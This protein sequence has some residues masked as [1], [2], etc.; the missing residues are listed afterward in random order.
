MDAFFASIEQRDDPGLKGKPVVVG[1]GGKRGVVAAASYESRAFGVRSAMPT[2]MALQRCP[3]L[4]I[5]PPRFGVYKEVSL[6][7][8]SI[9]K[10]YTDLVEPLSLD[11]AYLDVTQPKMGPPSASLIAKAIRDQILQETRLT[12][13]AGISFNKFLAKIASD[14]NKPNGQALI[15]PEDAPA[16]LE[17]LPIEQFHGVGKVTAER[18]KKLGILTGKDLKS[19]S[20]VELVRRFGKMGRH[21]F[22]MVRAQ[23]NRAVNPNRIRKSIGA[24]RTFSE[25]IQDRDQLVQK[26]EPLI[27][28]V[29]RVMEQQDNYGRTVTLKMKTPAFQILTRSRTFPTPV[30][31]LAELSEAVF[32]LL[33]QHW[34]AGQALRLIGISVSGLQ[35]ENLS[36]GSQLFLPFEEE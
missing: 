10:E 11:E 7:I 4:I 12:A 29:F 33:D 36:A 31:S 30:L 24:E 21:F 32:R 28:K 23:D 27:Q 19:F 9:F 5:V 17:K 20:E 2:A 26:L 35:L 8:R 3:D 14:L 18:M 1:G 16:F 13:S 25:N 15:T 34:E 22:Y 6:Q